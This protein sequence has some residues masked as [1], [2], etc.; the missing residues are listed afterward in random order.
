[1]P[2]Y[3]TVVDATKFFDATANESDIFPL[4]VV[5]VALGVGRNMMCQIPVIPIVIKGRKYYRKGA[6]LDWAETDLGIN[7]LLE[8]RAKNTSIGRAR[9]SRSAAYDHYYTGDNGPDE[10][11]RT[12]LQIKRLNRELGELDIQLY[13]APW[14]ESIE[15]AK[16]R[17]LAVETYNRLSQLK[18]RKPRRYRYSWWLIADEETRSKAH[19][20]NFEAIPRWW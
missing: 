2:D 16:L 10:R 11:G 6:I 17:E 14:P 3:I 12:D 9:R 15:T 13:F 5:A 7:L 18:R 4:P 1:M 20:E 19:R 8:L